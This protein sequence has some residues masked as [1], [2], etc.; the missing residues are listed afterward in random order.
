VV[1]GEI[2]VMD[3]ENGPFQEN[4]VSIEIKRLLRTLYENCMI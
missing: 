4:V 1:F 3:Q 2:A